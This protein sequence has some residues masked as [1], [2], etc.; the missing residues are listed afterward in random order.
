MRYR[1]DERVRLGQSLKTASAVTRIRLAQRQGI[2][3]L[4]TVIVKESERMDQIAARELGNSQFWWVIAATSGIGWC[5][6]VPPGTR[7]LVPDSLDQ[8][9]RL[10]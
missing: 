6:Q 9:L 4:R 8:I 2:F 3:R 10:V 5:M 7:L 1:S